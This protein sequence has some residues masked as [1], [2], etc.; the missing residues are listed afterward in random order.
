MVVFIYTSLNMIHR[1]NVYNY[2]HTY[3]YNTQTYI[4]IWYIHG[5]SWVF[6]RLD[7]QPMRRLVPSADD[8]GSDY[9]YIYMYIYIYVYIYR[10]GYNM[11]FHNH[12]NSGVQQQWI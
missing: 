12:S 11:I 6:R 7:P 10:G 8:S 9:M 2:T 4:L 1:Y 3:I 5:Y